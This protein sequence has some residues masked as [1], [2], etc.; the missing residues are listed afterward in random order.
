MLDEGRFGQVRRI[1]DPKLKKICEEMEANAPYIKA[2]FNQE[3]SG[4]KSSAWFSDRLW[5]TTTSEVGIAA[6]IHAAAVGLAGEISAQALNFSYLTLTSQKPGVETSLKITA[7][8]IKALKEKASLLVTLE[9]LNGNVQKATP[10][11]ERP[12][13]IRMLQDFA[14]D[15]AVGLR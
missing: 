7:K 15:R 9:S 8:E 6:A 13:F 1:R 3:V 5:V 11:A 12:H 14:T 2:G 10:E 4:S